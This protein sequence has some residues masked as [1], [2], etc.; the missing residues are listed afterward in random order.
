LCG[1]QIEAIGLCGD[2]K[3]KR[4]LKLQIIALTLSLFRVKKFP[5]FEESMKSKLT[6]AIAILFTN[7]HKNP[8]LVEVSANG[9][10]YAIHFA[11][12]SED[13]MVRAELLNC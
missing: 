10:L 2:T 9:V 3:D 8:S 13:L 11:R 1:G 6:E 12:H 5:Q 4:E 7:L